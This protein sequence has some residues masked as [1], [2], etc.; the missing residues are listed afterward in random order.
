[1]GMPLL[2]WKHIVAADAVLDSR[3]RGNDDKVSVCAKEW[4]RLIVGERMA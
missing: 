3:L 4:L 1:M 2:L